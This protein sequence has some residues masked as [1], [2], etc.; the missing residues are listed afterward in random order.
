MKIIM[1]ILGL[2]AGLLL[3]V[4]TAAFTS[5]GNNTV[6]PLIETEIQ[7]QIQLPAKLDIFY[8][9]MS[10]FEID[11]VLNKGNS[12][13]LKGNYSLLKQAFDIAYKVKLEALQT[14]KPLT[15][16][17]LQGSL[18]TEGKVVGD[19]Q[20]IHVDGVSDI[21]KSNT[22]YHVVLT[23]F[24]PTSIIAKIDTADLQSLLYML[25]QK[26]Y[27]SAKINLDVDFKNITPHKLEGDIVLLTKEGRLNA[28]VLKKDFNLSIPPTAFA[29]KLDA[30]LQDDTIDY[31]YNLHSNLATVR[32]A[33]AVVPQPL[34]VGLT[35]SVNV[36]ELAL[37]K[38]I[39]GAN[40]RGALRLAGDVKGTKEHMQIDGKSDIA[41]SE[42]TFVA[43][44]KDF[45]PSSVKA[46]ITGLKLQK[47]LYMLKQPHYADGV[48]AMHADISNAA[49]KNLKGIVRTKISK[50]L[51]DS[52]Y[53][54][55]AY[56]FN[57]TMPRTAFSAT[58]VSHLHK[59]LIDTK[60]DFSSTLADLHVKSAKFNTQ[61][62]AIKSDYLVK[63]HDLN[64][65]YFVT[66]RHL[67]GSLN[68][69]GELSKAKD[70][71][72]S[73]HS[74]VAGGV[75]DAKLH[76]DDFHA[77]L[78]SLQT[79]DVLDMLIYPKIF[80][81]TLD[82]DVDYNLADAKGTFKGFLSHG[83]FTKNKVLDLVKK[84]AHTDLYVQKFKGDVNANIN[85]EH[86]LAAFDLRSNTSFI[87]SKNTKLN[88]LKKTIYSKIEIS[89]NHNPLK[90]QLKGN[91]ASPE[92]AIDASELLQKEATK[93]LQ[94]EAKKYLK[95]KDAKKLQDEAT[96]LFKGLF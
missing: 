35:Y 55:K 30:K 42:T 29:M 84:Y 11:L 71:D 10:E 72:F 16:T 28:A 69:Y 18:H 61:A 63:V 17:Q 90:L 66:N 5:L 37:L 51:V 70:L 45:T 75:L 62:A 68:A 52:R 47:L 96:K 8:L 7:K 73:A 76:N 36:K 1:W 21:A 39:S 88:S 41:D 49:V 24:N 4:Y 86:I 26:K 50:G 44:L 14:L 67:K 13:H 92:V 60:L 43:V 25:N 34:K 15:Q 48:F 12:I 31:K 82:A 89:A 80:K 3:I 74:K 54:T 93:A 85:K 81:A 27:A 22:E 46:D 77:D 40:V 91:I 58:T 6:K 94:K 59:N 64:K 23:D 78:N 38:P 79:L 95:G 87:K 57:A 9:R 2:V 32:S 65:L 33:G 19:M 20:R 53:I 56:E 83:T